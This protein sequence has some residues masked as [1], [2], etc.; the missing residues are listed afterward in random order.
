[1]DQK[2]NI[3]YIPVSY[4]EFFDKISILSIKSYELKNELKLHNVN[5]E[6][7]LLRNLDAYENNID[8]VINQYR[9]LV[10]VNQ[11]L[12]LIED[13]LRYLESVGDFNELFVKKARQVY[14][15]N[16]RRSEIKKE[17]NILLNSGIIE[18]KLYEKY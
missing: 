14:I 8:K 11:T 2:N 13:D 6:L 1:M 7:R 18:E 9:E 16:D 5:K 17:I 4:G 15:C 3:V 10:R 12:W